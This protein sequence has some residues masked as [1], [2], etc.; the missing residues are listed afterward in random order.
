MQQLTNIDKVGMMMS[1]E[2][3]INESYKFGATKK[4]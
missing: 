2:V 4:F 1:D 3:P